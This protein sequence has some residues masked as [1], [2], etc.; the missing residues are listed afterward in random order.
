[1]PGELCDISASHLPKSGWYVCMSFSTSVLY[2]RPRRLRVLCNIIAAPKVCT[3]LDRYLSCCT[4]NLLEP[5]LEVTAPNVAITTGPLWTLP[6]TSVWL[7]FRPFQELLN[8]LMLLRPDVAANWDCHIYHYCSFLLFID[9]HYVWLVG[10]ELLVCL[11]LEVPSD[12]NS[13]VLN[14]SCGVFHQDLGPSSPYLAQ[15]FLYSILISSLCLLVYALPAASCTQLLCAGHL[16]GAFCTACTLGP[17]LRH[18][19][20][21]LS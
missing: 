7:F 4:W 13:V 8:L 16:S 6:S 1:M 11:N 10:K 15:M 19:F 21:G 5:S 9:H 14:P 2:Q 12:L 17:V 20:I 3:F 18:P